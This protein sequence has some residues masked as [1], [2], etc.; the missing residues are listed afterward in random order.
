MI[1]LENGPAVWLC[2][3]LYEIGTTGQLWPKFCNFGIVDNSC[4]FIHISACNHF[5]KE[6]WFNIFFVVLLLYY[7]KDENHSFSIKYWLPTTNLSK[8]ARKKIF[9]P[10]FLIHILRKLSNIIFQPSFTWE[11]SLITSLAEEGVCQISI[12]TSTKPQTQCYQI[13]CDKHSCG[14]KD[15]K[16]KEKKN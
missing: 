13:S 6:I 3:S 4:S 2:Y 14:F 11:Q 8:R 1:I 7:Q 5:L 15:Q 10:S 16:E 9:F 12:K